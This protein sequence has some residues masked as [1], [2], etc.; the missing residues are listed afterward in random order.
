MATLLGLDSKNVNDCYRV[1][2][3]MLIANTIAALRVI[4]MVDVD[5]KLRFPDP[6][7]PEKCKLL[8]SF[9]LNI[10]MQWSIPQ[11]QTWKWDQ[12]SPRDEKWVKKLDLH[13]EGLQK[14]EIHGNSTWTKAIQ[15]MVKAFSRH[16]KDTF[17]EFM[18][19]LE[20]AHLTFASVETSVTLA[21]ALV[22]PHR[23]KSEEKL[24]M[25]PTKD[26]TI[27]ERA[28][29]LVLSALDMCYMSEHGGTFVCFYEK[30]RPICD[31][32]G[33]CM[34][35]IYDYLSPPFSFGD[36][37]DLTTTTATT[38]TKTTNEGTSKEK[39]EK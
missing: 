2:L 27:L 9:F 24:V 33:M 32:T 5:S 19:L 6:K 30:H 36:L 25:I 21:N 8:V 10:D 38:T 23:F 31:A 1:F 26:T 34:Q 17:L 13:I 11:W 20:K 4:K 12:L 39:G 16:S 37:G 7:K 35:S 14:S 29:K 18:K 3:E 22:F 15:Y 28:K